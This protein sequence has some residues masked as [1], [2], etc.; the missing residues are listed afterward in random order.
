MS[1]ENVATSQPVSKKEIFKYAIPST[2]EELFSTFT[3]IIDSKMVSALGITY[4]SA[5][6]VTHQ[7][8]SFIAV[9]FIAINTILSSLIS[10]YYGKK[11]REKA[12]S[13]FLTAIY[14]IIILSVLIGIL[15]CVFAVPIFRL[16]SGQEDTLDLSVQYF[17]IIEIG[18]IFKQLLFGINSGLRG[19]GKTHL[20]FSSN[21][22]SCVVNICLNYLLIEGHFGF[23]ALGISGAAIAT[24]SGDFV[25]LL[26]TVTFVI[27]KEAYLS[28]RFIIKNK[29]KASMASLKELWLMWKET[30]LENLLLRLGFLISSSILA[31][32]GSF[33]VSVYSVASQMLNINYAFGRGFMS[34][35]VI[36][37]GRS[38]GSGRT[39]MIRKYSSV[40][41][42]I[43]VI[44]SVICSI[45]NALLAKPYVMMYN[46]DP[47]FVDLGIKA[48]LF[49][50]V[51][52][53]FQVPK[54]TITGML[55]GLGMMKQ[56]KMAAIWAALLVQP[57]CNVLLVIVFDFG[58]F[59]ILFSVLLSHMTWFIAS[60][61]YYRKG[62]K[63]LVSK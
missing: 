13:I 11:D 6:S 32:V 54:V 3:T 16:C 17:R 60:A 24:V 31:R 41:F 14:S 34:S 55:Q 51:T 30:I 33:Q 28:L 15:A 61:L 8:I 58:L 22:I 37:I 7:P 10:F 19:Y 29:V 53:L 57:L 36:L 39:D 4:I 45:V 23:P 40:L 47:T 56:T 9:P 18:L 21:A 35:A 25:A 26:F 52:S 27:K 59:G 38:R 43:A 49:I 46:T 63:N 50:A 42:K 44:C 48:C 12:N 1:D 5:V 2:M 20:T 62:L